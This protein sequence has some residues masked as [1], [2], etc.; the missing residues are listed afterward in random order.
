MKTATILLS[1]IFLFSLLPYS[2]S[3]QPEEN[4]NE[5][6]GANPD[7]CKMN[8]SL[9]VEFY[10][11]KN[12]DD[13]Y[14]PWSSVFRECPK[15][16]KNTYIHGVVI[17]GNKINKEKDLKLQKL[18][19]DTLFMIYDN[20]I[21]HFGEEGKVIGM[22]AIQY[23]KFFPKDIDKAYEIAKKSVELEGENSDAA[24]VYLYMQMAFDMLK[25]QKIKEDEVF[26][27]YN[28]CSDIMATL[29]KNNPEDE[30]LP[31]V[32]NNLDVLL[33]NSGIATCEK[34][35]SIFEPRYKNNSNDLSLVKAIVK[36]LDKQ[37]CNDHK[38]YA[39]TSEKLFE[40]EP[41]SLAAYSLAKYFVKAGS[42]SKAA[43]YY[44][45]AVDYPDENPDKAKYYYELAVVTGTKL[46]QY[47]AGR[48]YA[49]KA[50][51]LKKEWGDP[52]ILIG[53]IYAIC[54][55]E[56]GADNFEQSTVFWASVDKFITAKSVD[57]S[58]A[59]EA[60][61]LINTYSQYFPSKEEIFFRNLQDGQS[62]T[63][64]CWINETTK[65]RSR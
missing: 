8:L 47:S 51:E 5:K 17:V 3:G 54:S 25:A 12:Y 60:N 62:Y 42:Y 45:K 39:L 27:V 18:Y 29:L 20:R 55:K 28:I 4:D 26:N 6:W 49:L 38:L 63:V 34:I 32:Q 14:S 52:Y 11:Q 50:I 65:I 56:C 30:K 43:E 22:K 24:V 48:N 44:K 13:A 41:S 23:N 35:A 19:I 16:S 61:K 1:F 37:G 15:A 46:G 40:L 36:L 31:T 57:P 53:S 64:G 9:Y 21:T 7:N 58:C 59:D 2:I 33:I 10:R